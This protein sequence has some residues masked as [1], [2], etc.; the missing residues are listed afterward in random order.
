MRYIYVVEEKVTFQ[1]RVEY[2]PISAVTLPQK[3]ECRVTGCIVRHRWSHRA[4]KARFGH[5]AF[6][7]LLR[8]GWVEL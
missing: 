2:L 4:F 1:G 3:G 7:T 5:K 6:A 8:E